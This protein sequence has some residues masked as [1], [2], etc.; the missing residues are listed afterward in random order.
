MHQQEITLYPEVI[1]V[2]E[3][4]SLELTCNTYV[5]KSYSQWGL[6]SWANIFSYLTFAKDGLC[7]IDGFL[8]DSKYFETKCYSNTTFKVKI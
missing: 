3:N 6:L 5:K 7:I 4:S 8:A 2:L 1:D